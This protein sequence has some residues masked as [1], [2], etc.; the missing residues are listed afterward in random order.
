[1]LMQTTSVCVGHK[2]IILCLQQPVLTTI[3]SPYAVCI[4]VYVQLSATNDTN[5]ADV[6]CTLQPQ[7]S[8]C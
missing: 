3:R 6:L 1:M 8:S 5:G 4:S 7:E 2:C